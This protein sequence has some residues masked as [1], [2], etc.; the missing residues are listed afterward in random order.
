MPLTIQAILSASTVIRTADDVCVS[1]STCT[2]GRWGANC[3]HQCS[4]NCVGT[5]CDRDTGSCSGTG[6]TSMLLLAYR[7]A[8]RHE[9]VC[10]CVCVCV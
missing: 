10:V 2:D 8:C 1:G 7:S 5:T 3:E 6:H 4:D 9:L